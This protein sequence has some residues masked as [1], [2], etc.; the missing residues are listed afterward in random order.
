MS[1]RVWLL[2]AMSVADILDETIRLYR[3]NFLTFVGIVG[4][5]QAPMSILSTLLTAQFSGQYLAPERTEFIGPGGLPSE[6]WYTWYFIYV[7]AIL[8]VAALNFLIVN[9]LV[10]AALSKAISNRYLGDPVTIGSAYRAVLGHF[11]SLLGALVLLVLINLGVFVIPALLSALIPCLGLAILLGAVVLLAVINVRLAFITQSI[12]LENSNARQS[13]S[14]SWNLVKG[15]AWRTFGVFLLLWIFSL[16]IVSGPSYAVSFGLLALDVPPVVYAV[17]SGILSTVLAIIY[18]PIRLTGM[19][20]LYYDLR[21]RKEGL[22][23]ELQAAALEGSA[24]A[25]TL[26]FLEG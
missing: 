1:E 20:L 8:V 16:L 10:T 22:D 26:S 11:W 19:T 2:R 21:I 15:Y 12:V 14:R 3:H 25:E 5:L 13:L 17:V 24:D 6:D 23:L 4:I 9:N 7:G 18:T